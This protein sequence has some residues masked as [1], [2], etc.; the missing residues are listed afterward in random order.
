MKRVWILAALTG[1]LALASPSC[2]KERPAQRPGSASEAER[3]PPE[4][5]ID[6][7]PKVLKAA[8]VTYPE[9]A[10]RRGEEGMVYVKALVGED[11]K[12]AEAAVDPEKPASAVLAQAALEA[13]KQY[14]FEPARSKGNPVEVWIVVPVKFQLR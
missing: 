8:P 10:R 3:R 2:V 9:E 12:V 13:V 5:P 1:C 4:I 6:T 11:G 7:M 14:V